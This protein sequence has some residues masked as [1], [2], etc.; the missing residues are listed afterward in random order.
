[1]RRRFIIGCIALLGAGRGVRAQA[2]NPGEGATE[3]VLP[4]G[5]RS[6][7][8]GTAV[9][10]SATG[11]EA[12]WWNPALIARSPREIVTGIVS[13]VQPTEGDLSAV[14]VYTIPHVLSVALAFRYVNYGK[15]EATFDPFGGT[16]AFVNTTYIVSTTFAAPFGNRFSVGTTLKLLRVNFDCTGSCPNQ[17]QNDPL[18]GAVDIGAQFIARRD[19][20]LTFGA[21]LRNVGSKIQFND[22]P[23]ADPL[24]GRLDVGFEF[25]PRLQQ[26]PGLGIR[27]SASVV[28]RIVSDSGPGFRFGTE[29]SW[30][31]QYFGRVGYVKSGPAGSG[32]S[33]GAGLARGRWR[34]DFAEFLSDISA[35]VGA[36]PT[37]ISLRYLF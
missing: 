35:S 26:Y 4:G 30:M 14:G 32:P 20:V 11:G 21:A 27:A 10:A 25:A 1:V 17:P 13:G 34:I 28:S 8:L 19:S 6:M 16:G 33:I 22:S 29:V 24:P 7:G 36:R 5:A 18:T 37:Y 3:F 12:V 23:Q 2:G 9:V 15:Q 31:N